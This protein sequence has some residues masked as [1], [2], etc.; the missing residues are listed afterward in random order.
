MMELQ[1]RGTTDDV[2]GPGPG[3]RVAADPTPPDVAQLSGLQS[4][5]IAA[6]VTGVLIASSMTTG[7]L[8]V[9]LPKMAE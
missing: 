2:S 1:P 6:A 7:L 8:T 4:G 3:P 9:A 5:V